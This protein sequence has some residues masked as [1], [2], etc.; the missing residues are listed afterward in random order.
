MAKGGKNRALC[1]QKRRNEETVWSGQAQTA[2]V[3]HGDGCI[4]LRDE[5]GEE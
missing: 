5:A 4:I 3:K 1:E 2:P